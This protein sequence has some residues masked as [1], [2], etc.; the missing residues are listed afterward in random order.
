MRDSSAQN[1]L[2]II[3]H[4]KMSQTTLAACRGTGSYVKGSENLSHSISSIGLGRHA[5]L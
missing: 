5:T 4:I 2:Y 1:D 3:K